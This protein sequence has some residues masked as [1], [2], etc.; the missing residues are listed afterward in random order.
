[1][2]N[3]DKIKLRQV[4]EVTLYLDYNLDCRLS[5]DPKMKDVDNMNLSLT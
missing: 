4:M 3:N 1:M 2:L 5:S